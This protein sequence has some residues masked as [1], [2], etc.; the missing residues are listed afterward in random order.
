[1]PRARDLR[2]DDEEVPQQRFVLRSRVIDRRQWLHGYDEDMG[3]C[4]RMDIAEGDH[5]LVPV[6]EVCRDL[7]ADDAFE[8]GRHAR[9]A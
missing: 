6:H 2:G 3:R 7:A 1:M 5:A 9:A 8:E 4:T